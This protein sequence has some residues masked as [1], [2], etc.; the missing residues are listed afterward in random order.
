MNLTFIIILLL[1]G[2]I[3]AEEIKYNTLSQEEAYIIL[4]KGTEKPFSGIYCDFKNDGIYRCKQCGEPLFDSKSK[5]DS[6]SGWPSFDE[7]I[8]GSVKEIKDRDGYRVEIVCSR[9]EG[10][11]GHV[12][13]G[14]GFTDKSTRFCVNS[15]SLDFEDR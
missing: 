10:H 2:V 4:Q 8:E 13:R 5:F 9:C 15:A 3:L 11:L 12:F 1:K 6:R 14:E 7:A